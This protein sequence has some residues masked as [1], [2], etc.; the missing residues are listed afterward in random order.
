MMC[1]LTFVLPRALEEALVD[2]LLEHPEWV[3]GFTAFAAEGHGQ[4]V[5][6]RQSSEEVRGRAARFMVQIVTE[7]GHAEALVAHLRDTLGSSEIAW[8][9][10]PVS[11]FGRLA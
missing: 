10:T 8:W 4:G 7:D 9:L 2:Q 3:P 6:Y 11:A 1:C 5:V